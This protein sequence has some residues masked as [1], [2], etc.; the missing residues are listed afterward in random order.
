MA[1]GEILRSLEGRDRIWIACPIRAVFGIR[2][3]GCGMT[4]ALV[5]LLRG[6][7]RR[8]MQFNPFVLVLV[9]LLILGLFD[10]ARHGV[11]H[12]SCWLRDKRSKA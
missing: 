2:C 6:D 12:G 4:H 9:P 11:E 5:A 10:L 7:V 8:A 3:P 1:V